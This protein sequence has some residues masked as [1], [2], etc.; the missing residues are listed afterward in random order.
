MNH[1][2]DLRQLRYF[3][4][5]SEEGHVGRAALRLHMS[6]PPLSRQIHQLEEQLGV[7]L[8]VRGPAGM[9]LTGAGRAFLPEARK[10]LAQADKAVSVARAF[11]PGGGGRFVIGHTTVFDRSAIPDVAGAL[12]AAFPDWRIVTRGAHSISLVRALKQGGM[13]AAFIGLHTEAPGLTVETLREEALVLALPAGHALARRRSVALGEIGDTPLFWFERRLNP[14]FYDHCKA[15]F[16]RLG[17]APTTVPEP[18]EHHITLGLIAEGQGVA[19][20]P[21]SMRQLRRA[22]VVY[23]PLKPTTPALTMG[24]AIAY[25]PASQSP[26]LATFLALARASVG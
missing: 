20:V 21:A 14:G 17:F 9:T 15:L 22:G 1:A 19:L 18:L 23:R 10:T 2:I 7:A 6:Q 8:F 24:V 12:R 3:V 16:A 13:D 11:Q 26:A 25:A 4:A 5:L